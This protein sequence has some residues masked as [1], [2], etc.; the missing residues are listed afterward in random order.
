MSN[1]I[2]GNLFECYVED[3]STSPS[4]FV[5]IDEMNN[6]QRSTQRDSQSFPVFMRATAHNIPGSRVVSGTLSGFLGTGSDGQDILRDAEQNDTTV[7]IRILWDGT[8]GFEQDFKVGS[9][10]QTVAAGA[11]LQETSFELL[12]DGDAAIVGSGPLP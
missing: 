10:S 4:T 6:F 2:Q 12:G 7:R 8:N 9:T 11:T 5:P 3:V 1:P